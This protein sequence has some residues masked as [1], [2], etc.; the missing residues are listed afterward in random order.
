MLIPSCT[1]CTQQLPAQASASQTVFAC[2]LVCRCHVHFADDFFKFRVKFG[3]R[4]FAQGF[5]VLHAFGF[6]VFFGLLQI[7]V[8]RWFS[9]ELPCD[10]LADMHAAVGEAALV[11]R[12][13]HIY[14]HQF[15][16]VVER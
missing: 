11:Q 7:L 16:F 14:N 2:H 8:P 6:C 5:P 10:F 3:R 4:R 1:P 15:A 9:L 13:D 12:S